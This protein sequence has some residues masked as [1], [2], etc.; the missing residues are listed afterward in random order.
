MIKIDDL[1]VGQNSLRTTEHMEEMITFVRGGGFFSL[2]VVQKWSSEHSYPDKELIYISRFPD[3]VPFIHNGH[4]R[5]VAILVAG[6]D[7]IHESEYVEKNWNYEDYNRVDLDTYRYVT[8][9]DVKAEVRIPDLAAWKKAVFD[10]AATDREAA[11]KF[12]TEQRSQY[13]LPRA[14]GSV[15]KLSVDF[16]KNR[17]RPAR[18][19]FKR[20]SGG[21]GE[22]R[23]TTELKSKEPTVSTPETVKAD[24]ERLLEEYQKRTNKT[25]DKVKTQNTLDLIKLLRKEQKERTNGNQDQT[26]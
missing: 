17:K 18:S 19:T 10:L 25:V 7:H 1:L 3:G 13:V 16:Q 12:I 4:H 6:R 9:F 15:R 8:P 5:C 2:E 24:Q 14:F 11:L 26:A 20:V 21:D 22:P 23:V